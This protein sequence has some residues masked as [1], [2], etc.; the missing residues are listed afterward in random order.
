MDRST[1][2]PWGFVRKSVTT[3]TPSGAMAAAMAS[4]FE[5]TFTSTP[6]RDLRAMTVLLLMTD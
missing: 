5:N 1:G 3:G 2:V 4:S 6:R